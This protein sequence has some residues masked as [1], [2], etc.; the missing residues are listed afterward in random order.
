MRKIINNELIKYQTEEVALLFSGGMDSLSLLLSCLDVGIK[1]HLYTF[2]LESYESEDYKTS[3]EISKIFN[4]E[5][6]T[7]NLD[8]DISLL[9][10]D[11]KFIIKSFKVKKK[12]Q[13]QCIHPFIHM[14]SKIKENIV[15]S[16]LC[17]DELYGTPRKMQELGRCDEVKFNDKRKLI[18]EN[19][20][21][22]SYIFIKE[23]FN[24]NNKD[25]IVPYKEC[26]EL[27]SYM[28]SIPF[29]ELHTPKQKNIMYISYKEELDKYK[30]YRRNSS[31]QCNSKIRELHDNLLQTDLNVNK[32]KSVVAIYNRLYK[33]IWGES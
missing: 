11:I 22:S 32:N 9:L 8:E 24:M 26:N 21:S 19:N 6:T 31:L 18:N 30:L 14:V 5:L 33:E 7:V 25:L 28:L 20:E 3:V 29:K 27:V 15:L 16:G 4:L 12:T 2:K 23:L 13:I 1:P 10:N 17:A